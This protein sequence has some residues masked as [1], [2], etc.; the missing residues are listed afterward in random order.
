M[1]SSFLH[2]QIPH[3]IF[4]PNQLIFCL[5]PRVFSCVCFVHILTHGQDKLSTKATKCAF[6]GYS[7]LHRGYRCY[8]TNTN[9]YFISVNV[10][11]FKSS[12]FFSSKEHPHVSDVLHVPL[13][14]PPP[15]FPYPPTDVMTRPLHVYTCRSR[16]PTRPLADSS[17]MP[18]SSPTPVPQP[19]DDLPIAIRKGTRSTCNPHLV[20]NF[21]SY[22]RL[23]LPYFAFVSTLYFVFIPTSTSEALSH[24]G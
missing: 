12:S 15:D 19:L 2:D 5:P 11:F 17:F 18:P 21:L 16:P 20:Y 14:F 8:S 22:H 6:L 10:T 3:S 7:P 23:S 1:S 13:V 4:F 24:P 9:Q